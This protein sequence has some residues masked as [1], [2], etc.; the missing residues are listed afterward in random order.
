MAEKTNITRDMPPGSIQQDIARTRHDMSGTV[1]QIKE[2]LTPSHVGEHAKENIRETAAEGMSRIKSAASR[3]GGAI[4]TSAKDTGSTVLDAVRN[5]PVPLAMIGAGIAWLMVNRSTAASGLAE[6]GSALKEKAGEMTGKAQETLESVSGQMQEKG[7]RLAGKAWD[8]AGR[9]GRSARD[10]ARTTTTRAQ[11]LVR[12]NPLGTLLAVFGIGA[13][14]GFLIPQTRKEVE[15]MGSASESMLARA[16]DT[17]Q[18]T[19][20]KA[21]HAAEQAVHTAEEEFKKSA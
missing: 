6:R 15:I 10:Q 18:R 5:N 1:E 20:Q 11:E 13:M 16:K 3:M 19:F 17:A 8:S 12:E 4:S 21:Q 7:S 9:F 14:A 2:R